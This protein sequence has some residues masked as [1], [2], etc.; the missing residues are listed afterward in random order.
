MNARALY[1]KIT[2][3]LVPFLFLLYIVAYVDCVNLGFAAID[4]KR[5]LGFSDTVYG[6]GAGVF[7]LGYALFDMPSSMMIQLVG[8]RLWIARIMITWGLVAIANENPIVGLLSAMGPFWAPM[9]RNVAGS[10]AA[11]GVAMITTWEPCAALPA[12]M[13]QADYVIRPI[14][15]RESSMQSPRSRS[16]P[17]L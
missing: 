1:R 15:L 12:P 5:Q 14:A 2:W 17:R 9:T 3:R 10:A 11:A 4:M 13:L 7:F 6:T 16:W 8:T